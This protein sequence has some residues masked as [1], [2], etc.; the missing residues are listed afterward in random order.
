[1]RE[2][3]AFRY[4]RGMHTVVIEGDSVRRAVVR[5]IYTVMAFIADEQL[6]MCDTIEE[7]VERVCNTVGQ[8]PRDVL[9]ELDAAGL[10]H[11]TTSTTGSANA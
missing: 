7:A 4:L 6:V 9:S 5:G 8:N 3:R 11:P 1:M 10:L 2:V